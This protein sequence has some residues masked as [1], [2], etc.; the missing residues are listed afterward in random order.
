MLPPKSAFT[1]PVL[2]TAA[3]IPEAQPR[4]QSGGGGPVIEYVR[5]PMRIAMAPVA[6][7]NPNDAGV[8]RRRGGGGRQNR[9]WDRGGGGGRGGGFERPRFDRG[10]GAGGPRPM[11]PP[12]PRDPNLANQTAEGN[13]AP[14]ERRRR[15]RRRRRR[16]GNGLPMQGTLPPPNG[17]PDGGGETPV[18]FFAPAGQ[19]ANAPVVLGPDGQ[20]LRKRRRRRRRGRGGRQREW[21]GDGPPPTSNDDGGGG[22]GGDTSSPSDFASVGGDDFGGTGDD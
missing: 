12:Q 11:G 9:R 8:S 22:P 17:S 1:T 15:R 16:A 4:R 19:G 13:G 10:G 18:S 14:G 5:G 2:S 20:P 6:S 3:P 21:R 7:A